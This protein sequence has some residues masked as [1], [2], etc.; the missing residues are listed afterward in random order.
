MALEWSYPP[1]VQL[2]T[3]GQVTNAVFVPG[4]RDQDGTW[5]CEFSGG[6]TEVFTATD[7]GIVPEDLVGLNVRQVSRVLSAAEGH[8]ADAW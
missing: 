2:A 7:N 6:V 8:L 5:I 1:R 3:R 4:V